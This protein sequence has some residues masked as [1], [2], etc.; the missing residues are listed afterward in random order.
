MATTQIRQTPE[1]IALAEQ[2]RT[3]FMNSGVLLP[4]V[5]ASLCPEDKLAL[6]GLL[7]ED[8]SPNARPFVRACHAAFADDIL[9]AIPLVFPKGVDG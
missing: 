7:M 4:N 8:I 6:W 9:D 2:V 3:L 5:M 1:V